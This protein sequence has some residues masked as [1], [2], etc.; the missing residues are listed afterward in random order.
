MTS[1]EGSHLFPWRGG[2]AYFSCGGMFGN[3]TAMIRI[4]SRIPLFKL[5]EFTSDNRQQ[6]GG[7]TWVWSSRPI[8]STKA[9]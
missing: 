3:N 5:I 7:E 1:I 8:R 9:I 6:H 2:D 4:F